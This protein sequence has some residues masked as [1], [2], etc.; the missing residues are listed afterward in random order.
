[1]VRQ[2]RIKFLDNKIDYPVTVPGNELI[3][4]KR[5]FLK[6]LIR[7]KSRYQPINA[8]T[9]DFVL[10][11]MMA[12]NFLFQM[13]QGG[14]DFPESLFGHGRNIGKRFNHKI[15]QFVILCAD[16]IAKTLQFM[17]NLLRE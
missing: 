2:I 4:I 1:M 3:D 14:V 16:I 10:L 6:S 8:V 9:D 5:P 11:L 7:Q 13:L 12:V 15:G 17:T